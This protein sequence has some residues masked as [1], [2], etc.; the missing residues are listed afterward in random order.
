MEKGCTCV[1]KAELPLLEVCYSV[2]CLKLTLMKCIVE[3][4]LNAEFCSV[5]KNM[6]FSMF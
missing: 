4:I 1:L 2:A 3:I 6:Q 5:F